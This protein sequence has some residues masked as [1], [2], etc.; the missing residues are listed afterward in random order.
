MESRAE[1]NDGEQLLLGI[2]ADS[3]HWR[4]ALAKVR[5]V[6]SSFIMGM[7]AHPQMPKSLV[8]VVSE[9]AQYI[10]ISSLEVV[11][12]TSKIILSIL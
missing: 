4:M 12:L 7:L 3:D 9:V 1:R 10:G 5:V 6:K 11:C 2:R 8:E